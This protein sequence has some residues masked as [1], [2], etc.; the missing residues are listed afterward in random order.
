MFSFAQAS[1]L[2]GEEIDFHFMFA[3]KTKDDILIREQLDQL[4][5]NKRF[6]L[7]H[8]LSNET[9]DGEGHRGFINYDLLKELGFP[10]PADDVLYLSCGPPPFNV[11]NK[12]FLAANG[13]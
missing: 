8:V 7:H 12:S 3:N 1:L 9:G 5:Q 6:H 4:A 13:F 2:A 10:Q 11:A